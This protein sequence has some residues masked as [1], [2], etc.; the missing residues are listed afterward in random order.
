MIVPI[1]GGAGHA[2]PDLDKAHAAFQQ[3]PRGETI[4][5]KIFGRLF[6]EAIKLFR[7][8]AFAGEIEHLGRA[9]LHLGRQFV[10]S[11]PGIQPRVARALGL[12]LAIQFIK[13]GQARLFTGFGV[14]TSSPPEA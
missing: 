10:R 11:D 5:A 6:V 1:A 2:A 8:L 13:Q 7:G 4:A 9:Q 14:F 12:M 3:P